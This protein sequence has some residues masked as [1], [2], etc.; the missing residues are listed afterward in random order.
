MK[1]GAMMQA[2]S[3][4]ETI[5][6]GRSVD[7]EFPRPPQPPPIAI[8]PIPVHDD[9]G[10]KS[11]VRAVNVEV[12]GANA[13]CAAQRPPDWRGVAPPSR[14]LEIV[15]FFSDARHSRRS[16]DLR[17]VSSARAG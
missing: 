6:S 2:E 17:E 3:E 10:I 13:R 8:A 12:P 14:T 11:Q 15:G 1:A 7:F 9:G 4:R 5:A 16:G